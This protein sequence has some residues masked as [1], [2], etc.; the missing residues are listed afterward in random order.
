MTMNNYERER[1]RADRHDREVTININ[2]EDVLRAIRRLA[3]FDAA[4]H[5]TLIAEVE[6]LQSKVDRIIDIVVDGGI[7]ARDARTLI[8]QAREINRKYRR[9]V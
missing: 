8:R 1:E 4:R 9:E 7:T 6:A 5:R 2:N 3:A